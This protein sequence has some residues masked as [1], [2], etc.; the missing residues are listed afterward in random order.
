MIN[1]LDEHVFNIL[2]E[3][4]GI[5][6]LSARWVPLLLTCEK[7]QNQRNNFGVSIWTYSS[8]I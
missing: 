4:V 7:K 2:H 3:H 6:K 5:R 1:I 8:V